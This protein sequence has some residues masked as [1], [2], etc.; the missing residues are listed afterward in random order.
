MACRPVGQNRVRRAF[1][2]A[3]VLVV[4]GI[5]AVLFAVLLPVL[6]KAREAA[7]RIKCAA[8]LRSIG[9]GIAAYVADNNGVLPA[10]NYWKKMQILDNTQIPSTPIYGTVHWSSYLYGNNDMNNGSDDI[11]RS[12]AGW[13]EFRCPS[14]SDGGLPPANTF[15]GNSSL[16]NE[17]PGNDPDTGKPIVDSQAPRLSYTVNEALCPRGFFVQDAMVTG[18]MIQRPYRYVRAG[19]VQNSAGTVLATEIWGVQAIMEIDSLVNPNQGNYVSAARRPVSGF[20]SGLVGSEFLWQLPLGGSYA[21]LFP[22]NRVSVTDLSP[23]PAATSGPGVAP[24]TTLDWVGRNHGTIA[25]NSS[26]FDVRTTNFLYLDGHVENKN[27][28]DTLTPTF[29]WGEEFYSLTGGEN[30]Q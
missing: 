17:A 6:S 28:V 8:N 3:E 9:Q 2:L 11:Y 18:A 24:T 21:W 1:T 30:V 22:L 12:L 15:V 29:Q 27:I 14:L 4:I 5:L 19:S 25:H 16:A 13:D 20:R 7:N 23:D 10:S 26:G